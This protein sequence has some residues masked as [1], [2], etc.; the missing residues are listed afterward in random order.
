M[1]ETP[2]QQVTQLFMGKI[3]L[4]VAQ[5]MKVEHDELVRILI[6]ESCCCVDQFIEGAMGLVT[7]VMEVEDWLVETFGIAKSNIKHPRA[8]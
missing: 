4:A 1:S 8:F 6:K 3:L 5:L 2:Y 7:I